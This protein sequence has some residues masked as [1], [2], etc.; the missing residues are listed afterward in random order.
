MKQAVLVNFLFIETETLVVTGTDLEAHCFLW[1]KLFL[2]VL[3]YLHGNPFRL[4]L[5][6]LHLYFSS[7]FSQQTSWGSSVLMSLHTPSPHLMA[8]RVKRFVSMELMRLLYIKTFLKKI[9][10]DKKWCVHFL[11]QL[12]FATCPC[13]QS[14]SY[15]SMWGINSTKKSKHK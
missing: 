8:C 12:I 6:F 5:T 14:W 7:F 4:R 10:W 3:Q 9:K 13:C 2:L 1:Y 11:K 15:V